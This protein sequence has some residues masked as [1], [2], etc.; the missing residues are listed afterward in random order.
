[1]QCFRGWLRSDMLRLRWV[2][3]GLYIA[4]LGALSFPMLFSSEGYKTWL[5]LAGVFFTAQALFILGSGTIQLCQPIRKR[6]LWMPVVAAAFMLMVLMAGLTLALAELL[7]LDNHDAFGWVFF[8]VVGLGWVGWGVLLWTYARRWDRIRVLRRLAVLCFAG[9][10]AELLA[11]VPSHMIVSKRPGCLVG[12]ATML[13]IVAGCYVMLFSF[14]PGIVL[15]FL[16]PRHRRER[17][18]GGA[19][20]PNCDYD[21]RATTGPTCP[22]CGAAIRRP[23]DPVAQSTSALS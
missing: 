11:A 2:L 7:Y 6:R 3:L 8:G 16:R 15:L 13:G 17:M 14:G 21:L 4:L 19:L 23:V 12:L 22:E 9:S 18:E 1:M 20:C 5:L 10:L